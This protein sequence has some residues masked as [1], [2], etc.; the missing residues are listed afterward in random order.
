M[1]PV[2]KSLIFGEA[3]SDVLGSWLGCLSEVRLQVGVTHSLLILVLNLLLRELLV[4]IAVHVLRVNL[5]S[6]LR[7]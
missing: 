3:T 4:V 5:A 1:L 7:S 2:A 6:N